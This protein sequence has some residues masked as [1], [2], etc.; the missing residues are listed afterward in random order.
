MKRQSA[1][2]SAARD[3]SGVAREALKQA[4]IQASRTGLRVNH[5]TSELRE[6]V[7]HAASVSLLNTC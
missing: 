7:Y 6:Q 5:T 3:N 1:I 2:V 4:I